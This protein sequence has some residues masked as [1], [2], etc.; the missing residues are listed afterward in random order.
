MKIIR[1]RERTFIDQYKCI[2]HE[3]KICA[4]S[5]WW[6]GS[7]LYAKTDRYNVKCIGKDDII[8][9]EEC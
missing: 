5:T 4:Y 8:A 2:D 9:I 6:S 7:V 1:Y 3:R